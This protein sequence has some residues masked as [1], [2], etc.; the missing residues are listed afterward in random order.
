LAQP[1]YTRAY[2]T[3]SQGTAYGSTMVFETLGN[4][5]TD[6]RDGNVYKMVTIGDQIWMAENL[7]YL[8]ILEKLMNDPHK[9]EKVVQAFLKMKKFEID[10]LV[11]A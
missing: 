9:S 4:T 3:N 1:N 7:R 2:A 5:F 8:P 10:K 6:A 11:N